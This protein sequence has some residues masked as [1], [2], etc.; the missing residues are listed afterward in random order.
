LVRVGVTCSI[1]FLAL[2]SGPSAG[3]TSF[4]A[5]SAASD[6][7]LIAFFAPGKAFYDSLWVVSSGGGGRRE[8][9]PNTWDAFGCSWSP[10]GTR[11][12]VTVNNRRD[13]DLSDIFVVNSDGTGLTQ[14]THGGHAENVSWSP[15]GKM[16]AF[17]WT[18]NRISGPTWI[19][20]S[21][22]DGSNLHPLF[23]KRVDGSFHWSSN[24]ERITVDTGK[25]TYMIDVATRRVLR[26]LPSHPR[27]AFP[28]WSPDD[29][30]IAFVAST[31]LPSGGYR[32]D[33]YVASLSRQGARRLA[34][35]DLYPDAPAWSP[36]GKRIA[37]VGNKLRGCRQRACQAI[38][39]VRPD[40]AGLHRLTPYSTQIGISAALSW[41]PNGSQIAYT[42]IRGLYVMN[43]NG[44]HQERVAGSRQVENR[45]PTPLAWQP[46][47]PRAGG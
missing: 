7:S 11:L 38:F 40:G 30:R 2:V 12:A 25:K 44:T 29:Q 3:A 39:V 10:D 33:L 5:S 15:D 18:A 37:F 27:A 21:D 13:S 43:A 4:G 28:T 14:V 31:Q 19:D 17:E 34:L 1:L 22:T 8:L 35:P 46:G 6:A 42:S 26:T 23:S 47:Q 20:V 24:S 16:L 45:Y 9:V 32:E 36:D 41:S